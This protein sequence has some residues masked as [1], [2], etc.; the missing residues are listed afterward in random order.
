MIP[1]IA[2]NIRTNI[3]IRN[4]LEKEFEQLRNDWAKLREEIFSCEKDHTVYL[5]VNLP[6][7]INIAKYQFEIWSGSRSDLDPIT[8]IKMIKDLTD[9]KLNLFRDNSSMSITVNKNSWILMEMMIWYNLCS[10][11]VIL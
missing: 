6:R 4:E 5:P 9:N 1:E 8:V 10:K 7:L 11:K 3:D 2:E